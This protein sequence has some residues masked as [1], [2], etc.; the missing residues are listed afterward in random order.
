MR[1]AAAICRPATHMSGRLGHGPTDARLG[2]RARASASVPRRLLPSG[3]SGRLS[4]FHQDARASSIPGVSRASRSCADACSALTERASNAV[5]RTRVALV[6]PGIATVSRPRSCLS[7]G[8]PEVSRCA[9]LVAGA[10][11]SPGAVSGGAVIPRACV[12]VQRANSAVHTS[13]RSAESAARAVCAGRQ[14]LRAARRAAPPDYINDTPCTA[15]GAGY[16]FT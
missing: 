4:A 2:R 1:I 5:G 9:R 3:Q 15:C 7:V 11:G 12:T 14:E 6:Q 8:W 16:P 10:G 13:N